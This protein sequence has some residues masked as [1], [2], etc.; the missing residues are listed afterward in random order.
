[1]IDDAFKPA[2]Q[3][4]PA[5]QLPEPEQI[6]A[7]LEVFRR[8]KV[9]VF[10]SESFSV[11]LDPSAFE[12]QQSNPSPSPPPPGSDEAERELARQKARDTLLRSAG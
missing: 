3:T 11:E 2:G 7:Y 8:H 10:K 1:M 6:D 12:P 5:H 4:K 9:A